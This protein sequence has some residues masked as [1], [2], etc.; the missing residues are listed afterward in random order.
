[1]DVTPPQYLRTA[2]LKQLTGATRAPP[3]EGP[4]EAVNVTIPTC[5]SR[6]IEPANYAENTKKSRNTIRVSEISIFTLE[7]EKLITLLI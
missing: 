6:K 7:V 2:P 1:M 5:V 3:G 4:E